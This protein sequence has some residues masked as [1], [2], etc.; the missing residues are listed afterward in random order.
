MEKQLDHAY[1]IE[2]GKSDDL[3]VSTL[4]FLF[5]LR[6][7]FQDIEALNLT[8]LRQIRNKMTKEVQSRCCDVG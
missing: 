8:K 6:C 1:S 3:F 7:P 5:S 2:R 4:L